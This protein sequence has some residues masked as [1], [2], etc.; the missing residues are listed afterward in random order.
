VT[1]LL[2]LALVLSAAPS[3]PCAG[4]GTSLLI[5]T[6]AHRLH[7]CL[8]GRSAEDYRVALG[9]GGTD[10]RRQGDNKTPLGTYSLGAPRP[11]RRFGTFIPV[12][13]PTAVQRGQG[14]TGGDI[15]LHGPD[16]RFRWAGWLNARF[17]WTQG[18]VA[19]GTDAE[20]EA[21]VRW[22]TRTQPRS[23]HIE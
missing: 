21:I 6:D 17:D 3:D 9:K 1:G 22:V 11:S 10:K 2:A 20:I 4:R 15:G 7:L 19:L 12:G 14:Y 13:Y 23:V 16:R 18:C 8:S 5:Q